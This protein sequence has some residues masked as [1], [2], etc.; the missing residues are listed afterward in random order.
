VGAVGEEEDIESRK[1]EREKATDRKEVPNFNEIS[2]LQSK[3]FQ[4]LDR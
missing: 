4:C 1:E 2:F 3:L